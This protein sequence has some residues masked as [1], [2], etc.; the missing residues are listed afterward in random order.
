MNLAV[1]SAPV[2]G[3]D[4]LLVGPERAND[5][6]LGFKSTLLDRRLLLNANLFWTGI[7]GYQ[8]T[9]LYQAPGSPTSCR[10]WPTPA[11]CARAA[12]SSKPPRCP[13]AA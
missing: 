2:A 10:C 12:W 6:E 1:G 7:H 13:C 4:S 3:A 11:A 9:T 5:A 8:A